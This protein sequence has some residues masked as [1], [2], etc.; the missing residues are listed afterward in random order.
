MPPQSD[1]S[2]PRY[3]SVKGRNRPRQALGG[4]QYFLDVIS[5]NPRGCFSTYLRL[6]APCFLTISAAATA[7]VAAD[8]PS[9]PKISSTDATA[10]ARGT[11]WAGV[12]PCRG[13]VRHGVAWLSTAA[14]IRSHRHS[15]I[16][17]NPSC[18]PPP[19]PLPLSV[20]LTVASPALLLWAE[21]AEGS[22]SPRPPKPPVLLPSPL[23][24]SPFLTQSKLCFGGGIRTGVR[25][26]V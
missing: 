15:S 16:S 25:A 11:R 4:M 17:E 24:P 26:R 18:T 21:A 22:I 10:L 23:L 20:G 7:F 13:S 6:L 3:G 19:S 1:I 14:N 2:P 9:P 8:S 5:T 12:G